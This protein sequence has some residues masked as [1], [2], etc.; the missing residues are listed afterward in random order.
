MKLKVQLVIC[1][2]DGH[3]EQVQEV[4]TLDKDHQRLEH[5]GLTLA[6]TKQLLATLQQHVVAQQAATFLAAHAQC[7]D[8]GATL[9]HKGQQTRTFRTLFGTVT[10]DS[11]RLYHCRC[12]PRKT[13]TFRPLN[14]LVTEST[15]PELL[16]METK[17]AS[18]VS[19]G[20]TAQA[21]KDFLPVDATLNATT[22]Q[23]H[24]HAVAQRC[25]D[26]LGE[27]QW[28]FI[29]GCPA[30]W[31]TLPIPDGRSPWVLTGHMCGGSSTANGGSCTTAR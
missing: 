26:E 3:P 13:T 12:Q 1:T 27:E 23:N 2:D 29:D 15:A 4:A 7:D 18:L 24:T 19:Y 16:F 10:L 31:E 17:W 11:P 8:C 21:L 28:A 25:E 5:L 20:L 9:Q 30:T 6:E 14:A 22:V